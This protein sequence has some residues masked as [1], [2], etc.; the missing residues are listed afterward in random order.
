MRPAKLAG[1][2]GRIVEFSGD[3]GGVKVT[4][5]HILLIK[6][7]T[8]YDIELWGEAE[9]TAADRALFKTIYATWRPT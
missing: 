9:N 8:S 3:D 5:Q 4:I 1:W 6:G 2:S 7:R